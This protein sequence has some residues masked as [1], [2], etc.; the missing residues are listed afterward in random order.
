MSNE[1]GISAF[2]DGENMTKWYATIDGPKD[3]VYEGQSYR[4]SLEFPL[5][6]PYTAP[7][8]KFATKCY[9]PNVDNFG[10]IC[11]DILKEKWS[12]LYT[13][14]SILMSLRSLLAEPNNESPLN[15]KAARLWGDEEA[16]KREMIAFQ[17]STD[18]N[19]PHTI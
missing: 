2:P 3:T 12:A 9:H 14:K 4:L 19:L 5:N 13:V 10:N 17:T 8:V 15:G 1:S 16:Y 18:E 11:L 6:Y 7:I